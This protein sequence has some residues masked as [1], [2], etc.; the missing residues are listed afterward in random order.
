M[1]WS[2]GIRNVP[3]RVRVT[4]KRRRNEDEDADEKMYTLVDVVAVPKSELKG[5]T[6]K[7]VEDDA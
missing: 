3:V 4:M 2:K 5:L 1:V 6:T 7:T